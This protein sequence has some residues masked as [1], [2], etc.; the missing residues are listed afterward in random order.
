MSATHSTGDFFAAIDPVANRHYYGL[1]DEN[2]PEPQYST[3]FKVGSDNEPQRSWVEYAG[4]SRLVLKDENSAV[5]PQQIRQGPIKTAFTATYAG[6][7][8]ISIEAAKDVK[9]RYGKIAQAS[10]ALGSAERVTPE[11]LCALFM[12]GAFSTSTWTTADGIAICGT[13]VLPDTVTTSANFLSSAP[14]LDETSAE[15]V[16]VA[17][18][19]TL[20]PDGNIK[21]LKTKSWIV[22][23]AYEPLAMKLTS[24]AKTLGS[25]NNDPSVVKGTQVKVFDYLS[26]S[27]RWFAETDS[28]TEGFFWDWIEKPQFITDQVVMLLQKVYVS[29]FRARYGLVDWRKIFGSNAT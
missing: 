3:I 11:L 26:S 2:R 16:R 17:L 21:P 7:I 27:T 12:D 6:A 28:E 1:D 23:S 8:T 29:Y 24:S 18:R 13:H 4:P 20:G 19:G 14:A 15:D 22:P 10:G 9:N 25:A 5:Q